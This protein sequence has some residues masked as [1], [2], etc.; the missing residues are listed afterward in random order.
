MRTATAAAPESRFALAYQRLAPEDEER[1][2]WLEAHKNEGPE[3][4]P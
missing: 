1:N 3:D 2:R 4:A